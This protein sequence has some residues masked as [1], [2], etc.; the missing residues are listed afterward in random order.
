ML[1]DVPTN[2][3][4]NGSM[5]TSSEELGQQHTTY[6]NRLTGHFC[7]DTVFNLSK[8]VLSDA[9]IKVLEKRLDYAP[10]QNKINEP[11]LRRDF[12]NFFRQ[13]RLKWFFHNEPTPSFNE[14]PAF[15]TKSSWNPSKGHPCLEVYLSQV[16]KELF[17]LAV[18]HLGYSNF[19]KE[20]WTAIRSLA[21]DRSIIIKKAD[22]GSCVVVWD[23][24][25]Y[26]AEAEEQLRDKNVYQD[27][28]F[29]DRI[30]RDLV[31]KSNK[32]FRSLKSQG[33]ITEKEL[34]YFTYEYQKST[35]LGKMYLLPKI[36]KRLSNVPGRPVIWNCGTPTEKVSEFLDFQLKE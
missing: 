17:E 28:N 24:N 20:E 9:E 13:M 27:V 30:L 31:D 16:E 15:K 32:M 11:E 25:D 36:H 35:N 5:Q 8:K 7:S 10:I 2:V 22:K 1:V 4:N 19:T 34:K 12:E 3:D 6:E 23:R 33:K 18:S 21:D 26:I 14:T 29:S